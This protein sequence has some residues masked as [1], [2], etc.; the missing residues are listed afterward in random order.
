MGNR[1]ADAHASQMLTVRH[2]AFWIKQADCL[3]QLHFGRRSV[4]VPQ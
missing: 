3:I 2:V 4:M 1:E